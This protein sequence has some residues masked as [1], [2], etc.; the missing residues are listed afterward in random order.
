MDVGARRRECRKN[1][2]K[3]KNTMKNTTHSKAS[4]LGGVG[5]ST[6]KTTRS[7]YH[8]GVYAAP[9]YKFMRRRRAPRV[10]SR[11]GRAKIVLLAKPNTAR[12]RTRVAIFRTSR[13]GPLFLRITK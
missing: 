11:R 12:E 1:T 13:G 4:P 10:S 8:M 9:L 2:M 7:V 6:P 5:R 3:K